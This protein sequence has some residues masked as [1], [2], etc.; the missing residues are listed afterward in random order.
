MVMV[1]HDSELAKYADRVIKITDGQIEEIVVNN[2]EFFRGAATM[3]VTK[4]KNWGA[5]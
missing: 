5:G 4:D 1:T 2:E 3:P